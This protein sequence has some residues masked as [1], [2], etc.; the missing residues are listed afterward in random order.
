VENLDLL[1]ISSIANTLMAIK[2]ARQY[3]LTEDDVVLTV[4]T[5]SMELYGSRLREL[6]EKEGGYSQRQ[7][8]VDFEDCL[9]G[10][11]TDHVMDL[12]F[13][14]RKRVHNLKYYTWIE[15]QGKESEELDRQWD[16]FPEYWDNIHDQAEDINELI[17]QF[18]DRVGIL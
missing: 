18:N 4:F 6:R 14:T 5:D 10:Q 15:Q 16:E 9:M 2:F 1:G 7:A 11:E 13:E 12:D 8:A 3:E 17:K